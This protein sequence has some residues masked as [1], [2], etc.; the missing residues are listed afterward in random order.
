[1]LEKGFVESLFLE[2][3][4][5][6][7]LFGFQ[8]YLECLLLKL[9]WR[10]TQHS[11]NLKTTSCNLKMGSMTLETVGSHKGLIVHIAP[12]STCLVGPLQMST[13]HCSL[14]LS[15]HVQCEQP[16]M[17]IWKF[18]ISIAIRKTNSTVE[19]GIYFLLKMG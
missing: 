19:G 5:N 18:D 7:G 6:M 1:M 8:H 9:C 14:M 12:A 10:H 17:Q 16:N 2:H 15:A 11:E 3:S 4:K 13:C